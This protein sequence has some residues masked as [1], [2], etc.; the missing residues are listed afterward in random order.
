MSGDSLPG[1]NEARPCLCEC[2]SSV[3]TRRIFVC[4]GVNLSKTKLAK[5]QSLRSSV[6]VTK[7]IGRFVYCFFNVLMRLLIT[8][9]VGLF[10]VCMT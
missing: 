2:G 10:G 1:C 4:I 6:G 7:R 5:K 3:K 8:T 9:E